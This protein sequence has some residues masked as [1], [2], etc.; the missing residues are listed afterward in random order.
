MT[1]PTFVENRCT[2][3][4]S[5]GFGFAHVDRWILRFPEEAKKLKDV[6][7][8]RDWCGKTFWPKNKEKFAQQFR[9][10][11]KTHSCPLFGQT[12][13]CGKLDSYKLCLGL[14]GSVGHQNECGV[15]VGAAGKEAAE[16]IAKSFKDRGSRIPCLIRADATPLGQK[17]AD[18]V[19]TRPPQRHACEETYKGLYGALPAKLVNCLVENTP[20]DYTTLEGKVAKAADALKAEFG[21]TSVGIDPIDPL[22]VRAYSAEVVGKVQKKNPNYGFGKPS[23]KPGFDF[24]LLGIPRPV[25]GVNT[26]VLGSESAA[27]VKQFGIQ[28]KFQEKLAVVKPGDP[29]PFG[30][31]S[32]SLGSPGALQA[33]PGVVYGPTMPKG[34]EGSASTP[35]QGKLPATGERRASSQDARPTASAEIRSGP[36]VMVAGKYPAVWGQSVSVSEADARRAASGVCDVTLKHD[37]VNAGPAASGPFARRWVNSRNP[38]P[39]TNTYPAI[40]AGGTEPRTDTLSLKPGAN[41]LTLTLDYMDQVKE[42]NETNNVYRMTISVSGSCGAAVPPPPGGAPSGSTPPAGRPGTRGR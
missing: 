33:A 25:D 41:E 20:R 10:Y 18:F 8:N 17:P 38:V 1:A 35:M 30:K 34:L 24:A 28:D 39:F 7:S 12:L 15:A 27:L 32:P 29:D 31:A 37:A 42:S 14:L 21:A 2:D 22:V 4:F 26:P 3:D 11:L 19:C 23:G 40:P 6:Q 16:R 13:T 36:N 9:E 5:Q